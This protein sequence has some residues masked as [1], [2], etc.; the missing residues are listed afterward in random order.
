L[1]DRVEATLTE[2]NLPPGERADHDGGARR[3]RATDQR[4]KIHQ[5]QR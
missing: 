5:I 3:L 2:R 4:A 1:L